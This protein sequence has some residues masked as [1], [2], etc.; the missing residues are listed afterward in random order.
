MSN[1]MMSIMEAD[2]F[3]HLRQNSFVSEAS[4]RLNIGSISVSFDEDETGSEVL[5]SNLQ[6]FDLPGKTPMKEVAQQVAAVLRKG[7]KLSLHLM[8]R[9]VRSVFQKCKKLPN[10]TYIQFANAEKVTIVG[11]IHG[12]FKDLLHI[13]DNSG[14]PSVTNKYLFNGDLVDRG[15]QSIEVIT[16][17]YALFAAYPEYV[18]INRGNH[19]SLQKKI[20]K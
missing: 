3:K 9:I 4:Q 2:Q 17:V 19:V 11:D 10:V 13:L 5:P 12:Q 20:N 7:G 18:F 1:F 8:Y 15:G 14:W 16:L 6:N